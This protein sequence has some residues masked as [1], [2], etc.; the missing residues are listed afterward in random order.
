[1]G[2]IYTNRK[3]ICDIEIL[4]VQLLVYSKKDKGGSRKDAKSQR[5][6]LK[7]FNIRNTFHLMKY[8][9]SNTYC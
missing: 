1:M 7:Q 8:N 4:K 5:F 9:I 2:Q 3:Q 6:K